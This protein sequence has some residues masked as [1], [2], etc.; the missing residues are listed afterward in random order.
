MSIKLFGIRGIGKFMLNWKKIFLFLSLIFFL[1]SCSEKNLP[2][3]VGRVI[4]KNGYPCLY[5]NNGQPIARMGSDVHAF[6]PTMPDG[7][8]REQCVL[9]EGGKKLLKYNQVID[10]D[11]WGKQSEDIHLVQFCVENK[12]NI[13]RLVQTKRNEQGHAICTDLAWKPVK[14]YFGVF[15]EIER[16][17]DWLFNLNGY[18]KE[19]F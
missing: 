5:L 10:S 19:V 18:T 15:A 3:G 14:S 8:S 4:L 6:I 16:F 1:T 13:M 12:N 9:W 11:L 2:D 7:S 17:W